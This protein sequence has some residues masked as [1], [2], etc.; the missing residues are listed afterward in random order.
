MAVCLNHK[1]V[2]ALTTLFHSSLHI[3]RCM[4][5]S[6]TFYMTPSVIRLLC[7]R[8]T[9]LHQA[10]SFECVALLSTILWTP[11]FC[12]RVV[13]LGLEIGKG[14]GELSTLSLLDQV[15]C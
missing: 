10:F 5:T 8:Q 13:V 6:V 7:T 11:T 2:Y 1:F 9:V 15:C 3:I 12:P 14:G 4:N